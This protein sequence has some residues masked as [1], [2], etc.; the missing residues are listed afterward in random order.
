MTKKESKSPSWSFSS[1]K[2][3]QTCPKQYYHTKVLKQHPVEETEA[4][5]YGNRFHKMAE[6]YVRDG[7]MVPSEFVWAKATLDSL[8]GMKGTKHCELKFALTESLNPCEF[9]S[10]D[11]WWR[12]I[13]DLLILNGDRATVIDYKTGSSARYADT[14]Q[15]ELMALAVFKHYPEVQSVRAGL[16]FVVANAFPKAAYQRADEG[17]M[18]E[19]WLKEYSRMQSAY[20]NDVWNPKPSGLCKRHCPVLECPH[21]GRN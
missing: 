8:M 12:G 16:L 2:A 21:N 3:F 13:A 6:E 1:L 9:M 18:W 17:K 19:K 4:I 5:R 10:K 7:V 14:G 15:L 20:T 11:V